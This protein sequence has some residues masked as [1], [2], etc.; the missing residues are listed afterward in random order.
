MPDAFAGPGVDGDQALRE[1]V[2]AGPVPA[3]VVVGRR[4][5]REIDVAEFRVAGRVR[6]HVRVAAVLPR[7]AVVHRVD[8][9]GLDP[10]LVLQ[11]DGVERPEVLARAYVVAAHVAAGRLLVGDP[12]IGGDVLD[13]GA[14]DHHVVDDDRR[15]VPVELRE[16]ADEAE[17][18]VH[19]ARFAEAGIPLAGAGVQR[20][21]LRA[22][23][24]DDPRL[25][26]VGPPGDAAG[27]AHA[28]AVARS[29]VPEHLAGGG[30][31]R[32]DGAQAGAEIEHPA[33]HQ[34]R[35]LRAYGAARGVSVADG[36]GDDRL[37][38]DDLHVVDGLGI[39]LVE[40]RV[41]RAGLIGGVGRPL[42]GLRARVRGETHHQGQNTRCCS[43]R[44]DSGSGVTHLDLPSANR[45]Q[46]TPND[47]RHSISIGSRTLVS[48]P[49]IS[50]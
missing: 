22:Q 20:H 15:R 27:L 10:E 8:A 30:L 17:T 44:T 4:R 42:H 31:Q 2:V 41:L 16:R 28:H 34:R 18:Q 50:V 24:R 11:R 25:V 1:Q 47:G 6:P 40:R 38:P 45:G 3:V 43:S 46:S 12:L 33:G 39:D 35:G 5:Q 29:G 13:V 7:H 14:D 49:M 26:P 19:L 9:P 32:R 23:G 36:V 48:P 21:E 37:P